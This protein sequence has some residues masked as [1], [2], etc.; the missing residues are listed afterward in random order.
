MSE[1]AFLLIETDANK[2]SEII[3]LIAQIDG[4][5]SANQV[6]PPYNIYDIIT[7]VETSNIS[8]VGAIALKIKSLSGV[9]RCVT[10][11][12][13]GTDGIV[14]RQAVNTFALTRN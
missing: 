9:Y 3:N 1:K 7:L 13:T 12:I 8:E 14:C 6:A 11:V 10:C 5:K 2:T 4:I